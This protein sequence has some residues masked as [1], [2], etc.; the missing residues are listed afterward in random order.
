MMILK[1]L[2]GSELNLLESS[3]LTING[4]YREETPTTT[5]K[6]GTVVFMTIP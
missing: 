4:G 1:F 2:T 6:R 3:T 5:G